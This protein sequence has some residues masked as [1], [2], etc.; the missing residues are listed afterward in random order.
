V[1]AA[2]PVTEE[3]SDVPADLVEVVPA[4]ARIE[5]EPPAGVEMMNVGVEF[6]EQLFGEPVAPQRREIAGVEAHAGELIVVA[7]V[8]PVGPTQRDNPVLLTERDEM[9]GPDTVEDRDRFGNGIERHLAHWGHRH[10]VRTVLGRF[11]RRLRPTRLCRFSRRIA[12]GTTRQQA[13]ANDCPAVLHVVSA[14][15]CFVARSVVC[16]IF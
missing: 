16:H 4:P 12:P 15:R 2:E 1:G 9:V 5:R 13:A 10:R 11:D 3:R 6:V 8:V 14:C 7:R